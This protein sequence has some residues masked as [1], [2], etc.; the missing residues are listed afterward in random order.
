MLIIAV[1]RYFN[2][3]KD[4]IRNYSDIPAFIKEFAEWFETW[5]ADVA[6]VPARF[7]DPIATAPEVQRR[8]TIGYIRDEIDRLI[9]IVERE[10]GVVLRLQKGPPKST[11]TQQQRSQARIAQLAQIYDPPGELRPDG[12]RHDNDFVAIER[13][14]IAPT[15]AELFSPV[16]PYMP[17]FSPEAPHHLQAGSMER[18]LDIQFRLLREE[19]M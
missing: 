14:R 2:R 19:L 1:G 4:G 16:A 15:H 12:V 11:V 9:T 6:A 13:I 7:Q 18:H 3:Y 17:V 10:S 5:A 8:L